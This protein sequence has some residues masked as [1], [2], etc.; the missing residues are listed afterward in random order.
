V[1]SAVGAG[2]LK[3]ANKFYS[4]KV[5]TPVEVPDPRSPVGLALALFTNHR[6]FLGRDYLR[7]VQSVLFFVES[8][9]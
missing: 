1:Q 6:F 7:Y 4:R 8:A 9:P 2:L 5:K 3:V